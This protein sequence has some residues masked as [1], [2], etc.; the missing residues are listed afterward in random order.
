MKKS[1]IVGSIALLLGSI[2]P[3]TMQAQADGP[4]ATQ[5]INMTVGGSSLIAVDGGEVGLTL[6]AGATT[7]G[8]SLLTNSVNANS[9]LRVSSYTTST[10]VEVKNKISAK[11]TA[12]DLYQSHT[13][14]YVRL[15]A[16]T[17]T[18]L[19]NFVNYSTA[20]GTLQNQGNAEP[21]PV[22]GDV[23]P[24]DGAI[25]GT[26]T[27]STNPEVTLVNNIGFCWSGTAPGDGYQ[28][29]YT[30][31]PTNTGGTQARSVTITYTIAADI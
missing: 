17:V 11:I 25:I 6:S 1:F 27:S 31:A 3:F 22:S 23:F 20:G 15:L 16:P 7:A 18:N 8:Q 29:Q 12:G 30:Y 13:K 21:D 10:G 5:Q 28:I 24:E 2:S 14:L 9:R 19:S 4:T 26:S